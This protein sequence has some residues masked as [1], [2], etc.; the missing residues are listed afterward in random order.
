MSRRRRIGDLG[1]HWT[2]SLLERAGFIGV[3]DLNL[4]R[5]NHA[6]GDFIAE[7][8]GKKYFITVKARNKHRQGTRKLTEDTISTRRRF[9]ALL[10][11][12]TP[13]QLG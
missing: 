5:Y 9:G 13:S 8:D 6:G 7:R 1:E 4:V 10:V 11:N 3:R 12:T 2:K